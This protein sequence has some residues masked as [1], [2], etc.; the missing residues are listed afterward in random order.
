MNAMLAAK[1]FCCQVNHQPSMTTAKFT[2]EVAKELVFT[3]DVSV[4][5]VLGANYVPCI[6]QGPPTLPDGTRFKYCND[7]RPFPCHK[8]CQLETHHGQWDDEKF[9]RSASAYPKSRCKE[10]KQD[11]RTFC[12]CS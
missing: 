7:Q 2:C 5:E 9:A 10:C 1:I 6:K 8:L 3:E 4:A 12:Y 11:V